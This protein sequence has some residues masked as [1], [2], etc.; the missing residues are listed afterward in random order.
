[1]ELHALF[2]VIQKLSSTS[3][4]CCYRVP[5]PVPGAEESM[6]S[7]MSRGSQSCRET[8]HCIAAGRLPWHRDR[9]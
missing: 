7:D 3:V 2:F 4:S 5:T 6:T 9:V 1:V 8:I